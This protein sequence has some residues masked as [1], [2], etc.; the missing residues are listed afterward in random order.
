MVV[1]F[2][3]HVCMEATSKEKFNVNLVFYRVKHSL[4]VRFSR[5]ECDCI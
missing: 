4:S 5:V 3:I 2:K 1:F